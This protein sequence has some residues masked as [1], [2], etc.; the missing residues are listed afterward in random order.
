MS[1]I[2]LPRICVFQEQLP[3]HLTANT[4]RVSIH[5]NTLSINIDAFSQLCLAKR[6]GVEIGLLISVSLVFTH[7]MVKPVKDRPP[8]FRALCSNQG[9]VSVLNGTSSQH[10]M[11]TPLISSDCIMLY[12]SYHEGVKRKAKDST[13]G[14]AIR[15]RVA[16][17][18][19]TLIRCINLQTMLACQVYHARIYC[20]G[21]IASNPGV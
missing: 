7:A 11:L 1:C 16:P 2:V 8:S 5:V 17:L 18:D 19:T 15:P 13:R 9:M 4:S 3:C 21:R 10:R 14:N 12:L 6:D 20:R